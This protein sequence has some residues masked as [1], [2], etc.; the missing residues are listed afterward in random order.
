MRNKGPHYLGVVDKSDFHT[1]TN[2]AGVHAE[3]KH[4]ILGSGHLPPYLSPF[5]PDTAVLKEKT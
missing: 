4:V 5:T 2:F 1:I 3:G